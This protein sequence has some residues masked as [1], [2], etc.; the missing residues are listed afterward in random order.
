MGTIV[1]FRS[2]TVNEIAG[3]TG[4]G[5]DKVTLLLRRGTLK[6]RK[7]GRIWFSRGW[8]I[9]RL[10]AENRKLEKLKDKFRRR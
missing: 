10:M 6:G 2:Y 5:V 8:E 3:I 1:I 7:V 4:F 9:N